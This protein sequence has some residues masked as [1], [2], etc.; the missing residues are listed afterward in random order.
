M[1]EVNELVVEFQTERE[2]IRALNGAELSVQ[3]GEIYG[4]VGESGRG[5]TT[6]ALSI[7]NLIEPPGLIL[8]GDVIFEE[9]PLLSWIALGIGGG[10]RP[11]LMLPMPTYA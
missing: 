9:T 6:L 2:R 11:R 5:K 4:L 1:L 8:S 10:S 3:P 7:L